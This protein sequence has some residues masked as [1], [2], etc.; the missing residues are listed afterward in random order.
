VFL[1]AAYKR[2]QRD[3]VS[4]S[5]KR[6]EIQHYPRGWVHYTHL[7]KMTNDNGCDKEARQGWRNGVEGVPSA[8]FPARCKR[9]ARAKAILPPSLADAD[10]PSARLVSAAER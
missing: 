4:R 6:Y 10:T 9:P 8:L 1:D 5:A 3:R 7:G 2:C